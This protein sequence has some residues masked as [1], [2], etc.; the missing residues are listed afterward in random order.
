M[1][2]V[3][4]GGL[5]LLA[6]TG[7]DPQ[8]HGS[9]D[10]TAGA[11]LTSGILIPAST[12]METAWDIPLNP[13]TDSL[14]VDAHLAEQIRFGFEIFTDTPRKAPRLSGNELSCSN[15]HL[16]AGQREKALPLL[17]VAGMFP[18][19]NR[20]AG[21]LISLE[22][23]IV[24]C[25]N[26]S[27]N[28]TG[29]KKKGKRSWNGSEGELTTHT[30]EVLAVSA[31]IGWLSRGS[32]LWM[33]LPWRNQ[34]FIPAEELIPIEKLDPRLGKQQYL[35]KCSNCHGEDGEGVE[36]GDKKAGPLWGPRSWNDGAGAARTYTLA[37]I[38]RHM[39]PYVDPGGLTNEEALH[40]SAYINSKP[41]PAYPR[42]HEDYRTEKVPVDA[43]YYKR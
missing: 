26:R 27:M 40:I 9:R 38:I 14:A 3:L 33:N 5:A 6:M 39:M 41:R 35:E 7:I 28:T 21:R 29:V 2:I 43:V 11:P 12:T 13:L 42:K 24:E 20:R 10:S 18:E 25:F 17:G 1:G 23:R 36:I 4:L 32:T 37:G 16:N 31:Y 30:N 19:Y 15:C 22:D 8:D 34:N